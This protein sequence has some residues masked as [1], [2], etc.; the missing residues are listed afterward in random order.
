MTLTLAWKRSDTRY[1]LWTD[2]LAAVALIVVGIVA[3]ADGEPGAFLAA[4]IGLLP[5]YVAVKAWVALRSPD[6]V[7][8]LLPDRGLVL[9]HPLLREPLAVAAEDVH[10][11]W[12]GPFP[13][14][15]RTR[16]SWLV[17]T[18]GWPQDVVDATQG[19]RR[20]NVPLLIVFNREIALL[21]PLVISPSVWALHRQTTPLWKRNARGIEAAVSDRA[22]AERFVAESRRSL[23]EVPEDVRSWLA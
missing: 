4:A 16:H 13:Q 22:A 11:L 14:P 18:R 8:T 6:P 3:T 12:V 2:G 17:G 15:E 7:L 20:G 10:S 5:G 9:T 19:R 1:L 21:P 23:P